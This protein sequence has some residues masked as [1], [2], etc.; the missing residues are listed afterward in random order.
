[1]TITDRVENDSRD[2]RKTLFVFIDFLSTRTAHW[3]MKEWLGAG[4]GTEVVLI[5]VI[6]L[7]QILLPR[8]KTDVPEPV[9]SSELSFVEFQEI[10]TEKPQEVQDL[11]DKIIEKDK[12]SEEK[13]INWENA[14]DP[15]MDPSQ[16]Y[17][18]RLRVN[19]SPDDYPSR[20]RRANLG[21]VT[22]AV[23][24]YISASGKIRDVRVH[25]IRS[26]G[27]SAIQFHDDFKSA[28]RKILLQK[29][30]LMNSPY[31]SSEGAEDF[32]WNTTVTFTLQ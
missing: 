30:R 29:T 21:R 24:L 5:L 31:K 17:V 13:P 6:Y 32:V 7:F 22:V 8:P 2:R 19:I 15:A 18:A 23:S 28:V 3:G 12:L 11:S 1:M 4:L 27:D 25:N 10:R 16:R 20:A 14:A 9:L 26:Q